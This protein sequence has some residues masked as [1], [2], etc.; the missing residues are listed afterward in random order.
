[1]DGW[2]EVIKMGINELEKIEQL[3]NLEILIKKL[4]LSEY[5]CFKC[6]GNTSDYFNQFGLCGVVVEDEK[7]VWCHQGF[8]SSGDNPNIEFYRK[9]FDS[10]G[11]LVYTITDELLRKYK[12]TPQDKAFTRLSEVIVGAYN[13]SYKPHLV[14]FAKGLQCEYTKHTPIGYCFVFSDMERGHFSYIKLMDEK[15][16]DY[17]SH[18]F[19]VDGNVSVNWNDIISSK[20]VEKALE[21]E[22]GS[23]SFVVRYYEYHKKFGECLVCSELIGETWQDG[24]YTFDEAGMLIKKGEAR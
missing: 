3:K 13:G 7:W 14:N 23:D 16:P 9:A 21:K 4:N 10:L 6:L 8:V 20:A 1:M 2:G 15:L 22:Y 5:T 18:I 12:Q 11:E 19:L 17:I 24:Y